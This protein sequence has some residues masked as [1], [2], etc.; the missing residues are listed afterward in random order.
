[1]I[2]LELLLIGYFLWDLLIYFSLIE[3]AV[4]ELENLVKYL[5]LEIV[6]LVGIVIFN[7]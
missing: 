2:I 6:V 4:L 3:V 5:L 1:M 7:Y